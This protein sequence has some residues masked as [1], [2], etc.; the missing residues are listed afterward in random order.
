MSILRIGVEP[1]AG[2][3]K[4]MSCASATLGAASREARRG[5]PAVLAD[6]EWPSAK[7]NR[8]Y[9]V[10]VEGKSHVVPSAKAHDDGASLTRSAYDSAAN[11]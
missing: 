5:T 9:G 1:A 8:M 6:A 3:A 7:N 2:V 11:A 10:Q 4:G